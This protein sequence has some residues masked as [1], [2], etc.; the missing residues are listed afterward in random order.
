[1]KAFD[2]AKVGQTHQ[3][4]SWGYQVLRDY[5]PQNFEVAVGSPTARVVV[6][7]ANYKAVGN[8]PEAER[9]GGTVEWVE[10]MVVPNVVRGVVDEILDDDRD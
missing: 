3:N 8:R 5:I 7:H 6:E 4:R 9:M 1:M 2:M 10:G